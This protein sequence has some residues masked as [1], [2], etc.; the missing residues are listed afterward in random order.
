M[1]AL[2]SKSLSIFEAIGKLRQR[3]KQQFLADHPGT[4]VKSGGTSDVYIQPG[5]DYV[6]KKTYGCPV[7]VEWLKWCAANRNRFVPHVLSIEDCGD[8]VMSTIERLDEVEHYKW[9]HSDLPML[10]AL[11][12]HRPV[13]RAILVRALGIKTRKDFLEF[14]GKD[15]DEQERILSQYKDD[16]D[17]GARSIREAVRIAT[18]NNVLLDLSFHSPYGFLNLLRRDDQLVIADPVVSIKRGT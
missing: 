18:T 2:K 5:V 7:T 16:H 11:R 4:V 8:Y 15:V 9:K 1:S 13:S 14:V 3:D 17:C 12:E 10:L 6:I